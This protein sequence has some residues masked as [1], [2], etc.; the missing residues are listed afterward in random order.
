MGGKVR[1]MGGMGGKVRDMGAHVRCVA[2]A[3][4][5][6]GARMDH[7]DLTAC[8][9]RRRNLGRGFGAAMSQPN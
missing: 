4:E 3:K 5:E 7:G 8:H 2:S 6:V 1:D 9:A